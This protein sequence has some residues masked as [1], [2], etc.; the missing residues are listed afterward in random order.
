MISI[1]KTAKETIYALTGGGLL[2]GPVEQQAQAL[3]T[4][5]VVCDGRAASSDIADGSA[6][7]VD[8]ANNTIRANDLRCYSIRG[9]GRFPNIDLERT[10]GSS[11]VSVQ[12]ENSA[13]DAS[14]LTFA[15]V[16][17]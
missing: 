4:S 10:G 9:I 12:T 1:R 7:S 5:D 8:F 3:S 6:R 14:D 17:H 11:S 13:S 2:V 15:L 16:V